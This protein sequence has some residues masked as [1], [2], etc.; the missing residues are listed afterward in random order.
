MSDSIAGI[1]LGVAQAG[2]KVANQDD[3]V[4][5][6][7]ASGTRTAALFTQNTFRAAPVVVAE[8]HLSVNQGL[9]RLLLINTGNANAGTGARDGNREQGITVYSNHTITPETEKSCHY[10]WHHARNYRLDDP[11]LTTFLANAAGTAFG[12]DADSICRHCDERIDAILDAERERGDEFGATIRA[13]ALIRLQRWAEARQA[14]NELRSLAA[15]VAVI[16]DDGQ[17]GVCLC[18]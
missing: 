13:V 14:V 12:E 6:E 2:L 15:V 18:Q 8:R 5:V 17:G 7:L 11:D 9:A 1:R 16:I 3:L 10:F 4:V